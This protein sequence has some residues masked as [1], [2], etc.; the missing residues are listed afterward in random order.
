MLQKRKRENGLSTET[1]RSKNRIKNQIDDLENKVEK[2][3]QKSQQKEMKNWKEP[4]DQSKRSNIW[5]KT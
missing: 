5:I 4:E 3:A 1:L 2:I